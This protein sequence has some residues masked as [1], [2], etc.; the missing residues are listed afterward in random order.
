M[1]AT[2]LCRDKKRD[3]GT[4]KCQRVRGIMKT[5]QKPRPNF[6]LV[7]RGQEWVLESKGC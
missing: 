1:L 7:S 5:L 2:I 3:D 4:K 6:I